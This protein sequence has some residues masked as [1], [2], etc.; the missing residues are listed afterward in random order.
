MHVM[1][2]VWQIKIIFVSKNK[3]ITLYKCMISN[4]RHRYQN[5]TFCCKQFVQH[6]L[7][8]IDIQKKNTNKLLF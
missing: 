6:V 4:F 7:C 8:F 3:I 2:Q 5:Y 1:N